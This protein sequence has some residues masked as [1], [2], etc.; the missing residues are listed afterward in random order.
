LGPPKERALASDA[1]GG[2]DCSQAGIPQFG[3][4]Y[5]MKSEEKIVNRSG[6]FLKSARVFSITNYC[7]FSSLLI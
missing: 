1:W 6:A 2:P 7:V 5:R 3:F 4:K